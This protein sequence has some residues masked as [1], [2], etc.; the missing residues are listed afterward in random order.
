VHRVRTYIAG[1]GSSGAILC[2]IAAAFVVLGAIVSTEGLP[3]GSAQS[4]DAAVQVDSNAPEAAAAAATLASLAPADDPAPT[5]AAGPGGGAGAAAGAPG[6][7][8]AGGETLDPGTL[9]DGTVDPGDPTDPVDPSPPV[10]P[11][12]TPGGGGVSGIVD[13]VDQSIEN[14]TGINPGLGDLT[15]PATGAVDQTLDNLQGGKPLGG[16]ALSGLAG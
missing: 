16:G 1:I 2:A 3:I 6:S 7:A 11:P 10:S 14:A 12:P 13:N 9:P 4:S 5:A 8:P 15:G